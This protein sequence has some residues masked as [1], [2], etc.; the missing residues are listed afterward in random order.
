LPDENH[1]DCLKSRQFR[2]R[3]HTCAELM[4][5]SDLDGERPGIY[6]YI[7][8]KLEPRSAVEKMLEMSLLK[9][10]ELAVPIS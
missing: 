2:E 7:V 4:K 5:G 3:L 6:I 8:H 10:H 9:L 1:L